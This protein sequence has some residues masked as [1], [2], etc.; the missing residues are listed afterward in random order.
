MKKG[1]YKWFMNLSDKI[2]TISK[3]NIIDYGM[4]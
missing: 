4:Y 2:P 3:N 1:S